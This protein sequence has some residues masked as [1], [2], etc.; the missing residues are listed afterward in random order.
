MPKLTK[1]NYTYDEFMEMV[2]AHPDLAAVKVHK[3]RF[4]YMVNN[5][6][7]N[8]GAVLINGAKGLYN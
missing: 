6:T 8:T 2:Y 7:A 4:G 1:D 3:Q 5:T